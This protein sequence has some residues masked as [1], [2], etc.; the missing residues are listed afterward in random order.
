MATLNP[1]LNFPGNAEEAFSFY[2][3]VFGG[4][5]M[6]QRF[7]EIPDM[8]NLS[9]EDGEK[10]MHIS[11]PI[12]DCTLMASDVLSSQNQQL[13]SGNNFYISIDAKSE[14]EANRFFDGLSAGGEVEMPMQR[15]FWNAYFGMLKDPYGIKWMVNY[16]YQE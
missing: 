14:E 4:D 13:T 11:F 15:T 12:G 8:E 7:K 1:Y 5:Y 3:S 16:D 2:R 10:A 6:I 9:D